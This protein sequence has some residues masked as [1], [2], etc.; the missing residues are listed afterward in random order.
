MTFSFP[1]PPLRSCPPHYPPIFTLFS[2]QPSSLPPSEPCPPQRFIKY[3]F[4]NRKESPSQDAALAVNGNPE[5]VT[6]K[7][8]R[9]SVFS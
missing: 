7:K 9:N 2:L 8:L 5:R 3:F 4:L 1:P 6:G